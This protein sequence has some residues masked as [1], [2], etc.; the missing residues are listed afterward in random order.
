MQMTRTVKQESSS[1][2]MADLDPALETHLLQS[3]QPRS[4]IGILPI[5]SQ[6]WGGEQKSTKV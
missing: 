1:G 4:K 6:S 3:D 5:G 2:G